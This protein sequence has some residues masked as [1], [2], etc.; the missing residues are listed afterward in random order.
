M[1]KGNGGEMRQE[2]REFIRI[3]LNR[4]KSIIESIR[5]LDLEVVKEF[6]SENV[7]PLTFLI[8]VFLLIVSIL[9]NFYL[10][11]KAEKL[12]EQV[13]VARDKKNKVLAE[14][15]DLRNKIARIEF[16]QKLVKH[17]NNYNR[18]IVQTL[19]EIN[20]FQQVLAIQNASICADLHSPDIR[21]CD[22]EKPPQI[23]LGNPILQIDIVA[24]KDDINFSEYELIRQNYITL[25]NAPVKRFCLQKTV[26]PS[27][28]AKK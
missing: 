11:H 27:E 15:R 6:V 14:I 20:R 7:Y 22:I 3:N 5:S 17:L 28:I 18:S 4:K 23:T 26:K 12:D 9:I 16:Q 10:K 19:D 8:A 21:E 13:A 24:F 1:C 25:G 2:K